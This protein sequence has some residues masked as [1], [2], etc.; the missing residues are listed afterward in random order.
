M[1]E[2]DLEVLK[3]LHSTDEDVIELCKNAVNG[4][5]FSK[6]M[7]GNWEDYKSPSGADLALCSLVAFQTKDPDQIN[8]IFSSS[9]LYR[10][11]WDKDRYRVKTI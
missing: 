6:L 11:K 4:E 7:E 1:G 2:Q 3:N 5:K 10:E 8:R 9:G